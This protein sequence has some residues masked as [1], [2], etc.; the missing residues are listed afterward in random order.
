MDGLDAHSQRLLA[1]LLRDLARSGKTILYSSHVLQQVEELCDELILIHEGRLLWHGAL[2]SLR[3]EHAGATLQ[4]IFLTMTA[5][6]TTGD[7]ATW[8]ALLTGTEE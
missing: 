3:R 6:D 1:D 8:H 2:D 5:G 4:E 7:R